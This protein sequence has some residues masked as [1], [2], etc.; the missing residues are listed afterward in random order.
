MATR[1]RT[2]PALLRV[3]PFPGSSRVALQ[4]P[5]RGKSAADFDPAGCI[6]ALRRLKV[7]GSFWGPQPDLPNG[8]GVV[9][10]G[11]DAATLAAGRERATRL[12][13]P[14]VCCGRAGDRVACVP[15]D[16]DPWHLL[17]WAHE[18]VARAGDPLAVLAALAGVPVSAPGGEPAVVA[19]G[20]ALEALARRHLGG[21]WDFR[22]PFSDQAIPALAAIELLGFWRGLI[23]ANRRIGAV[24][25]IAGWKRRTVA[26]LLWGGA[27][28]VPF[29]AAAAPDEIVAFWRA[30][31]DPAVL[32]EIE[33]SAAP[34]AE[35]EDGFIRSVGLGAD[36]VPPLSIVVEPECPHYDPSGPSGLERLLAGTGFSP[37]LVAR[38]AA[39]RVRIVAGGVSKYAAGGAGVARADRPGRH[40]LVTGQV[41]DDLSVLRGGG[42]ITS[43]LDLVRRVRACAPDAWIVYR[44]HP[45][46]DAGHRRGHV[47]DCV[48]LQ[49]ADAIARGGG[50]PAWIDAVDEVHVL[51]SLAGFEALLRGKPVTTHGVPFYAGWGLTTDLGAVPARRSTKRSLDELVA[52]TLLVY[53]RYLDPLTALPC[54]PEV[55]VERIV[56]G[57]RPNNPLQRNPLLVTL[58]RAVG[59]ARSLLR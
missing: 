42:G 21:G 39:L 4:I 15:G 7:G 54:P 8:G 11:V 31:T 17:G 57:V 16:C 28:P 33:R 48:M 49:V 26:P 50:I 36:C 12:G 24:H 27:G 19:D 43:N 53:P 44:P 56:A 46:V 23:D 20:A 9:V 22:D 51:T 30:R 55:L 58:R 45:D 29:G 32:A 34:R 40:I 5:A 35:I 10:V 41:E 14:L 1:L 59:R 38:A 47:D 3:P 37:A 6:A 2:W 13:L 18:V 25:G 52:A